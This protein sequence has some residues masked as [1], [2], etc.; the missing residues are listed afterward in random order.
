MQLNQGTKN[1]AADCT[2]GQAKRRKQK[3]IADTSA[4]GVLTSG[5][6]KAGSDSCDDAVDSDIE[7]MIS[8]AKAGKTAE[9]SD[10]DEEG[11]VNPAATSS[12]SSSSC[13]SSSSASS[14]SSRSSSSSSE[15]DEDPAE[16]ELDGYS[17]LDEDE[18]AEA[19]EAMTD[20]QRL[21][22]D[23]QACRSAV[24]KRDDIVWMLQ[25]LPSQEAMKAIKRAW[26]R[27]TLKAGIYVLAQV[28][29]VIQED[30]YH[31][32]GGTPS[33]DAMV[34]VA[35]KCRRCMPPE[36][37]YKIKYISNQDITKDEFFQW[38]KLVEYHGMDIKQYRP[39]W[40]DKAQDVKEAKLF[41][42]SETVVA[43]MLRAKKQSGVEIEFNAQKESRM[44]GEIQAA[45]SQMTLCGLKDSQ[46]SELQSRERQARTTL[47]MLNQKAGALQSE[48]F[49]MRP[50]MYSI[51]EINGKN[52][53]RQVARDKHALEYTY[54]L[55]EQEEI[56][57]KAGKVVVANPFERRPCRPVMLWDTTL[58]AAEGVD[59]RSEKAHTI[60]EQTP[61]SAVAEHGQKPEDDSIAGDGAGK[62]AKPRVDMRA[63]RSLWNLIKASVPRL[64]M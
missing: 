30:A 47:A 35:L 51:R 14:S 26:V 8:L 54:S 24:L 60:V 56:D 59:A 36:R 53:A 43:D 11:K 23:F 21:E 13:S 50:N 16:Q 31:V 25:Q 61:D 22:K 27:L 12:S 46:A 20:E 17:G 44:R 48:W 42:F 64:I 38:V 18:K 58:T 3:D 1:A 39:S 4:S 32:D 33:G 41:K 5:A 57:K 49:Q 19:W 52:K 40:T 63:H 29:D 34:Q 45:V 28:Y 15:A 62:G 2:G 10:S 55:Q 7:R 9:A 37:Q 6:D